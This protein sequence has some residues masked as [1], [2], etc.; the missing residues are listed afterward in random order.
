M[1][2]VLTFYIKLFLFLGIPFGLIM[3]V[4]DLIFGD[5]I[6]IQHIF[7]R[8]VFFGGFMSLLLGTFH[9]IRLKMNGV[10][11]LSSANLSVRQKKEVQSSADFQRL[12]NA[13]KTDPVL[14]KMDIKSGEKT[15]I[16]KSGLNLFSWGERILINVASESNALT[17]YEISSE[18]D[19]KTTFVDFG[20]NLENITRIEKVLNA[21]S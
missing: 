16:L 11:E 4:N 18:P 9:I 20:K 14:K 1:K 13:I 17:T 12:L 2:S 8:V 15:V 21:I 5:S 3:L 7:F 6:N 10:G 19:L